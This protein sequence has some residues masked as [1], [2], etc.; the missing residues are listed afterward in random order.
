MPSDDSHRTQRVTA[1]DLRNGRIRIPSTATSSTKT[2]F[3]ATRAAVEVVLRGRSVRGS[4]DPRMGP[5]RER[6]GVLRVGPALRD[7]VGEDD[8][9]SAS[10]GQGGKI[11]IG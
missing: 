11:L 8:V 5:D 9:L 10:I 1:V 6:S 2:V 3:P 7:L 4:W